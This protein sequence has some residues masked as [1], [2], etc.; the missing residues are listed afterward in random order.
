[1]AR[2]IVAFGRKV[3]RDDARRRD[4]IDNFLRFRGR[5]VR[6]YRSRVVPK[7][8]ARSERTVD[9]KRAS[10]DDKRTRGLGVSGKCNDAQQ[11]RKR[12]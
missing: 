3:V 1:M 6:D 2:S 11:R 10:A 8:G 12:A 9:S 7:R 5:C 4:V